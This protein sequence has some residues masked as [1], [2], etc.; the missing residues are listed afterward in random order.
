MTGSRNVTQARLLVLE[1][2]RSHNNETTQR[3]NIEKRL[4]PGMSIR[5]AWRSADQVRMVVARCRRIQW[6]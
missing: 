6:T 3:G 1:A 5:R 2:K 4:L